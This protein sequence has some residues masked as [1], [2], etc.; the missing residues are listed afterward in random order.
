[1]SAQVISELGAWMAPDNS[2]ITTVHLAGILLLQHLLPPAVLAKYPR[3]GIKKDGTEFEAYYFDK[4]S[5][6]F[7]QV[8]IY[9]EPGDVYCGNFCKNV[10][11]GGGVYQFWD[12]DSGRSVRYM[13]IWESGKWIGSEPKLHFG[14]DAKLPAKSL[15]GRDTIAQIAQL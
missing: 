8:H 14:G 12:P 3:R 10:F 1:M 9:G 13:T 5:P 2:S 15:R 11:D 4:D 6:K 7:S